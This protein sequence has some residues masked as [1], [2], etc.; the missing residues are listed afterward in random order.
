MRKRITG[1]QQN[2]P[3]LS[4]TANIVRFDKCFVDIKHSHIRKAFVESE[5]HN[6]VCVLFTPKTVV[7]PV[8]SVL[9]R[10]YLVPEG[11]MVPDCV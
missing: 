11:V 6:Y 3:L 5:Y 9:R 10:D 4:C 7:Y 2:L 1:C 8:W